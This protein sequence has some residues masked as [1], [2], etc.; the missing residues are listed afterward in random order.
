MGKYSVHIKFHVPTGD[1][2]H[3]YICSPDGST[4]MEVLE[5][6]IC[7]ADKWTDDE[8]DWELGPLAKEVLRRLNSAPDAEL[9]EEVSWAEAT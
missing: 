4:V 2:P 6:A 9:D 5:D 3:V 8:S 1:P 7:K